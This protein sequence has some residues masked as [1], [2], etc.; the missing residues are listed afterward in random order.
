MNSPANVCVDEVKI[1][2]KTNC[3]GENSS[4]AFSSSL[5]SSNS[6]NCKQ[7]KEYDTFSSSSSEADIRNS[8]ERVNFLYYVK[9]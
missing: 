1:F 5:C 8:S 3:E 4:S 7:I 2:A 9:Y 6:N